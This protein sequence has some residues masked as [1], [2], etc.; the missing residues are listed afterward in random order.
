MRD[1]RNNRNTGRGSYTPRRG[2]VPGAE[3]FGGN[4]QSERDQPFLIPNTHAPGSI[5]E[6]D[7]IL[8]TTDS[9]GATLNVRAKV[10]PAVERAIAAVV[11]SRRFPFTCQADFIRAA[12]SRLLTDC[13]AM[14]E[15]AQTMMTVVNLQRDIQAH[16]TIQAEVEDLLE[17]EAKIHAGLI[18][19]GEDWEARRMVTSLQ[20]RLNSLP[21]TVH[22][23]SALAKFNHLFGQSLKT[24]HAPGVESKQ[25][26]NGGF[27]SSPG[28]DTHPAT[29][30]EET[31]KLHQRITLRF[32]EE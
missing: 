17:V 24:N 20:S 10:T 3:Y 32:A 21:D 25:V 12:I 1:E 27:I 11:Q 5:R 18:A 29:S 8:P 31:A 7:Y 30:A 23:R 22:K 15:E 9:K 19:Q 28:I 2:R 13:A 26:A 16:Y 4:G 14:D 6:Q